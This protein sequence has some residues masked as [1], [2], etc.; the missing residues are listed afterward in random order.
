MAGVS[1]R[2]EAVGFEHA[3]NRG[4]HLLAGANF[5]GGNVEKPLRQAGLGG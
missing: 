4:E 5:A 3:P 1:E 2:L